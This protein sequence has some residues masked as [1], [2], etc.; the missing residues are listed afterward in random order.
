[1]HKLIDKPES[2]VPSP[3]LSSI[4]NLN[5]KHQVLGQGLNSPAGL[6]FIPSD[7]LAKTKLCRKARGSEH[8]QRQFLGVW[9]SD[10][11]AQIQTM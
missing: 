4:L 11:V 6:R 8:S 7:E 2:D 9:V 5:G 1:M 10:P 3:G